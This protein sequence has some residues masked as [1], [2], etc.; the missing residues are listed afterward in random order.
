MNSLK[1]KIV[2]IIKIDK[3]KNIEKV[4]KKLETK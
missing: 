4:A 3:T 1:A 2:Y